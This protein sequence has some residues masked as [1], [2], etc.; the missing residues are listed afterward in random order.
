MIE[1]KGVIIRQLEIGDEEF[2]Y[3]WWND[4]SFM[5]HAALVYGTLE[6]KTSIRNS[7]EKEVLNSQLYATKRRI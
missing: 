4:G 3:K 5:S 2:L 1:G 7:I 6:S